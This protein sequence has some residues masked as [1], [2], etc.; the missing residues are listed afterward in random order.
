MDAG[1]ARKAALFV[2][3]DN[4]YLS[5]QKADRRAAERFAR[6]PDRWLRWLAAGAHAVQSR[7]EAGGQGDPRNVLLRRCYLTPNRFG[8]YRPFFTRAGF[9]VVD[10][11][12]LTGMGKNS[13][14]IVMVMD[15]LD[16]LE[17]QTRFEEFL[18]FSGDADFTPVLLRLR[19]HDRRTAV[20]TDAFT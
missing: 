2:D 18:V 5:L 13:A 9:I 12:P 10:C 16:A 6:Q 11:P 14:D 4:I 8:D 7:G 20:L 17:H 1:P 15:I 19:M 3:F